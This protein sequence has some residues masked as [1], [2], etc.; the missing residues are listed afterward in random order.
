M[1]FLRH[2]HS[3]LHFRTYVVIA[4]GLLLAVLALQVVFEPNGR[5]I[6]KPIQELSANACITFPELIQFDGARTSVYSIG[7][8]LEPLSFTALADDSG[9]VSPLPAVHLPDSASSG[10]ITSG[11]QI[12]GVAELNRPIPFEVENGPEELGLGAAFESADPIS[13]SVT[14][15]VSVGPYAYLRMAETDVPAYEIV[16][17]L[18]N[19]QGGR[20]DYL[21][22]ILPGAVDEAAELELVVHVGTPEKNTLIEVPPIG[23]ERAYGQFLRLSLVSLAWIIPIVLGIWT[24]QKD[25]E[26]QRDEQAFRELEEMEITPLTDN[27]ATI[28]RL[29]ELRRKE[30]QRTPL[31]H[32][33]NRPIWSTKLD[34]VAS[35]INPVHL[36]HELGTLAESETD[37]KLRDALKT[38]SAFL[39][40]EYERCL[41]R[42]THET[43]L[44]HWRIEMT[45]HPYD[46]LLLL[47]QM[48]LPNCNESMEMI[49]RVSKG[50][51]LEPLSPLLIRH[52]VELFNKRTEDCAG[53][54]AH[55]MI[56]SLDA[57]TRASLVIR[58]PKSIIERYPELWVSRI[59]RF[60]EYVYPAPVTGASNNVDERVYA[61]LYHVGFRANPFDPRLGDVSNLID[62]MIPK[63]YHSI[64]CTS[65]ADEYTAIESSLFDKLANT[66]LDERGVFPIWCPISNS[67]K[68]AD[69]PLT[70][71]L[72]EGLERYWTRFL[73]A[74]PK[75]IFR[76]TDSDDSEPKM[77]HRKA[78]GD[79]LTLMRDRN[80]G[81]HASLNRETMRLVNIPSEREI[82]H[83]HLTLMSLVTRDP[84]A[85]VVS[86]RN[87]V[88]WLALRPMGTVESV[89]VLA[90]GNGKL[91]ANSSLISQFSKISGRLEGTKT[92][93]L[94]LT[95]SVHNDD[96]SS[97]GVHTIFPTWGS[98]EIEHN[99]VQRLS[100]ASGSN[101]SMLFDDFLS[102]P[103]SGDAYHKHICESARGS[104]SRLMRIGNE[105][106]QYHAIERANSG[107]FD[108]DIVLDVLRNYD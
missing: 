73:A 67:E 84:G 75:C 45:A 14:V 4:S 103:R 92:W 61:W 12:S 53:Q 46:S 59:S 108:P 49:F 65:G 71:I 32:H 94:L 89:I 22:S 56:H 55:W 33:E 52:M 37:T 38:V 3:L 78:L 97:A 91:A 96:Y 27:L 41:Q 42:G 19:A 68:S 99:L 58:L 74:N 64:I 6:C 17:E 70:E 8:W 80:S 77:T 44:D 16:A 60:S 105:I 57:E 101:S 104:L 82:Q 15:T 10:Q 107:G 87:L 47:A 2:W 86:P 5:T 26:R 69:A 85:V 18:S 81:V 34:D 24:I 31:P 29:M 90:D 79:M 11:Q 43:W 35:A 28:R 95:N 98:D 88:Q 7:F 30:R 25:L 1:R 20:V 106:V 48:P 23:V 63:S 102:V 36:F 13:S 9:F 54:L 21:L 93:L 76:L 66:I 39:H 83:L 62:E 51:Y 100:S 72:L 40:A 50:A